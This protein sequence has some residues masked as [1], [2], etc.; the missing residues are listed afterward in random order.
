MAK[1]T[2]GKTTQLQGPEQFTAIFFNEVT[3]ETREFSFTLQQY[4]QARMWMTAPIKESATDLAYWLSES[5]V[6][7]QAA[8]CAVKVWQDELR[9]KGAH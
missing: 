5:N 2:D 4:I 3:G 1:S 8:Y 9:E 6:N 7:R